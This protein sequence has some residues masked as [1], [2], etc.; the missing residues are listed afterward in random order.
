M[1]HTKGSKQCYNCQKCNHSS[2]T[3]RF[4]F[5]CLKCAGQHKTT[6]CKITDRK[7]IKCANYSSNHMVNNSKCPK[8]QKYQNSNHP[9]IKTPATNHNSPKVTSNIPCASIAE[10]VDSSKSRSN[11][12][13]NANPITITENDS[14]SPI[15]NTPGFEKINFPD[16]FNKDFDIDAFNLKLQ[17]IH[18]LLEKIHSLIA[19]P[20]LPATEVLNLTGI[21][22]LSENQSSNI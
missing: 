14:S 2:V 16:L 10:G 15:S 18:N 4:Y 5:V 7:Y 13:E 21:S 22:K 6:D 3:R 12:I 9:T 8:S 11:E 19:K 20:D 17:T 1:K